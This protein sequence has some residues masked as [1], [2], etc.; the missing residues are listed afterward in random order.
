[1]S[2]PQPAID[3]DRFL[4]LAIPFEAGLV[5]LAVLWAWFWGY[6]LADMLPKP[7]SGVLWGI[8]A[9][10]PPLIGLVIVRAIPWKPLRRVGK[11]LTGVLGP[12]LAQCTLF[13]LAIVALLAGL[14]EEL[15]FRGAL[16]PV[17][18]LPLASV[19]V[20]LAHSITPTYALLTGLMGLYL[21][22]LAEASGTLWVPIATHALYDFIAFLVVIRDVRRTTADALSE[23]FPPGA[24]PTA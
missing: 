3:R 14:G 16:Q 4:R 10:V 17:L 9:T 1:M 13:E 6:S 18:G 12:A 24:P 15:L 19:L 21:G 5:L 23:P 8:V 22:W 7:G 20:A 11:F 2:V